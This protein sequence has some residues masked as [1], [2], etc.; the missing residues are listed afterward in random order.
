MLARGLLMGRDA[1]SR[2]ETPGGCAKS[3]S[4]PE[5]ET[6]MRKLSMAL[7]AGVAL[8]GCGL[9]TETENKEIVQNLVQAGFPADDI[10]V[11]DGQVY[12]GRDAHVTLEAS[13]EM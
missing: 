3:P 2:L 12:V 11:V 7:L 9:D 1:W 6:P 8:V 13:R 4:F 10:Q 5:K